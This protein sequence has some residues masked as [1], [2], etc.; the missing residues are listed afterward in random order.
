MYRTIIL[1]ALVLE[2]VG[3]TTYRQTA[4]APSFGAQRPGTMLNPGNSSYACQAEIAGSG[5]DSSHVRV[6]SIRQVAGSRRLLLA[7]DTE[8]AQLLPSVPNADRKLYANAH[9]AWSANSDAIV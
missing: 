2:T 9:L 8:P 7:L 5:T 4:Q 3:C 6:V 1:T